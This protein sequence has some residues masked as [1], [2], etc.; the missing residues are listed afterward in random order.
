M[1]MHEFQQGSQDWH[2]FRAQHFCA[3]EASA[4]LG[5]SPYKTRT[6]LLREK[7]TGIA[8]DVDA[9]TQRVFDKGHAVEPLAR[10]IAEQIVKDDL[11]PVTCSKGKLSASCDGLT[12]DETIAFENK[13]YNAADFELVKSGELP[14][15]HWPQCQQVLY[16]TGAEKLLFMISNGTEETTAHLWVYPEQS[17][18]QTIVDGWRQ[19][20]QDLETFVA[21]PEVLPA[22]AEPVMALPALAINVGGS[23]SIQSNLDRFGERLKAFIEDTNAKPE[24]DLDFANL[25]QAC[26]VLKEA[27]D[28]LKQAESNA[29]AQTA[30]VDEMRRT[31]AY[32]AD[33][34]R[35]NRLS[36][37]KAVKAEKE[38]RKA[39]IVNVAK[40]AY[41]DH[42]AA[43]DAEITGVHLITPLPNFADAIK[44]KKTLS[45]MQD[46]VNVM[47]ANAKIEADGIAK[48]LRTNLALINAH[49][50]YR[51]L[52]N[53]AGLIAYKSEDD[54]KNII[55]LRIAEHKEQ[56]RIKAE[57]AAKA[58]A[59]RE[60]RIRRE[61]E[62]KAQR[63]AAQRE[64]Q[65]KREA[66]AQERERIAAE[67]RK[68]ADAEKKAQQ[69]RVVAVVDTGEQNSSNQTPAI[70]A[71]EIPQV[72]AIAGNQ[73][74]DADIHQPLRQAPDRDALIQAIA[75]EFGVSDKT[76]EQW[77]VAEFGC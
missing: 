7:K 11:Y 32:L 3:S 43:L 61:A 36:F 33:M 35:V 34:A 65:I 18:Q 67:Q 29:L 2:D 56:E 46:A 45:S 16:V 9:A 12:L 30:S 13:Q 42:H 47:L 41:S 62:E 5:L 6:Q 31:V 37:E 26:K 1:Q 50:E 24:T 10:G 22:K 60:E 76:A 63:E 48:N 54:V 27:E 25:E 21:E 20:E 69:E 71:V 52:F 70:Q 53:D 15:K 19:F 40:K 49:P 38:N 4:M 59:E 74:A 57:Q 75:Y 8:P 72:N 44:G 66:A 23:I 64:E 73:P 55:A 17:L 39:A 51:F 14:E 77:L 58:Q 68:Q 28:A